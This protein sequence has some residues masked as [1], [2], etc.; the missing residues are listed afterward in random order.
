METISYF[1]G[2][3]ID[4]IIDE[5]SDFHK[6]SKEIKEFFNFFL[7]NKIILAIKQY[8]NKLLLKYKNNFI[9]IPSSCGNNPKIEGANSQIPNAIVDNNESNKKL[10]QFYHSSEY[11]HNN[12]LKSKNSLKQN[13]KG[14]GNKTCDSSQ[15]DNFHTQINDLT[16]KIHKR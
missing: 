3:N 7:K 15:V 2:D 11:K 8:I 9:P 6:I 5:F 12:N 14:I 4:I 1:F 10:K 16:K 13:R